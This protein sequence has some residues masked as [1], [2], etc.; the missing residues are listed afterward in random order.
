MM[1][2]DFDAMKPMKLTLG[3]IVSFHKV[4]QPNLIQGLIVMTYL[5][6]MKMKLYI[7]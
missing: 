6:N 1:Y 2:I 3:P 4:N 5:R 7:G